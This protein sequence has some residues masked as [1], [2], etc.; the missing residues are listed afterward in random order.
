FTKDETHITVV[1]AITGKESLSFQGPENPLRALALNHDGS[2][3]AAVDADERREGGPVGVWDTTTG[4]SLF[5][6][7]GQT[8]VTTIAFSPNGQ[9]I[10]TLSTE[11]RIYL[12]DATGGKKPTRNRRV[13]EWTM[14]GAKYLTF[15][16]DGR[17]LVVADQDGIIYV[18][19][20]TEPPPVENAALT[21]RQA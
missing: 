17:H 13:Q 21:D 8:T 3:V 6:L 18:L 4:K 16:P 14:P 10:A 5:T 9:W 7:E 11:G 2:R 12:H 19:R 20:L 15:A 1:D